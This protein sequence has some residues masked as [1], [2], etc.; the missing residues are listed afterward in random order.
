MLLAYVPLVAAG[1]A[2]YTARFEGVELVRLV[3]I[4]IFLV[5]ALWLRR[6]VGVGRVKRRFTISKPVMLMGAVA[7]AAPMVAIFIVFLGLRDSWA[8]AWLV[9]GLCQAAFMTIVVLVYRRWESRRFERW[10]A[11]QS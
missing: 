6:R 8:Y 7:V 3:P 9:H 10:L 1:M 4:A 11:A 5:L 2:L